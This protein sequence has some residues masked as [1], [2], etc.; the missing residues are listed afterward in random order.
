M[1]IINR[2]KVA[3]RRGKVLFVQ[4]G[5]EMQRGGKN[6]N[7]LSPANVSRLAD[8]YHAFADEDRFA[9]VVALDE[10]VDNDYN[11]NIPRYLPTALEEEPIDMEAEIRTLRDLQGQRDAA[12]KNMWRLLREI[13]Y[14]V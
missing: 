3:A 7:S 2:R 6:Q 11:L 5:S 13:G 10:I 14:R 12:E 4:G 1:L 9:R 8:A